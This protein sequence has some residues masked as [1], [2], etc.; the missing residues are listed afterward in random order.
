MQKL[1]SWQFY[2]LLVGTLFAWGNF[3]YELYNWFNQRACT[4]GCPVYVEGSINPFYTPCF[5]GAIFFAVTFY[6]S[7]QIKKQAAPGQTKK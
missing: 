6:L 2:I 5:Y 3:A 7:W 1:I 4:T